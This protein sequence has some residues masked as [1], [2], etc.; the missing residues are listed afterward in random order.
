M[1]IKKREEQTKLE[2]R[3]SFFEIPEIREAIPKIVDLASWYIKDRSQVNLKVTYIFVSFLGALAAGI[4][5]LSYIER[6]SGDVVVFVFGSLIGYVFAF[7]QRYL[8]PAT[9]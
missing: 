8:G 7:L 1:T 2:S 9:E 3:K 6:I 4:F 5:Y